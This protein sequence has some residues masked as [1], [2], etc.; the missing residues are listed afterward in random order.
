MTE[1]GA[2]F[3][4]VTTCERSK[5]ENEQITNHTYVVIVLTRASLRLRAPTP[6]TVQGGWTPLFLDDRFFKG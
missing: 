3:A 2:Q 6:A 4:Y 1:P 5:Y